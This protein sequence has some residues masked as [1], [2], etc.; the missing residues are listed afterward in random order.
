V[1]DDHKCAKVI[2]YSDSKEEL[3]GIADAN[4]PTGLHALR[5][6]GAIVRASRADGTLRLFNDAGEAVLRTEWIL[7]GHGASLVKAFLLDACT[8]LR[9]Y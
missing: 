2:F 4:K 5:M 1:Q 9:L 3:E 8:S 7:G 6:R